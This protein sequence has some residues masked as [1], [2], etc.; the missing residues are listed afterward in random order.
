[1]VKPILKV[2]TAVISFRLFCLL[3]LLSIS[4]CAS[5][6][7]ATIEK[8]GNRH[9]EYALS[10]QGSGT[11]VFENGLGGT[12]DWWADVYPE[13]A[14][15]TTVFAYNRPGY[16][17][18]DPVL[19]PRDGMHIVDELRS[20]LRSKGLNPPYV[21]VGHSLGGLYMQL[22]ARRFPDEVDGLILVD[23]THPA[24]FQ[25]NGSPAHWPY[26]FHLLYR[27]GTSEVEK[28][29][30]AA[31]NATGESVLG[32]PA[33]IGK[34]VV[35]LSALKPMQEKSELADDANEKR[36][37]IAH[38]YPG[39]KQIWVDSGHGIPLEKPGSVITAIRETLQ[40]KRRGNNIKIQ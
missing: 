10:K 33:F 39:A 24:Q 2:G 17:E 30:M 23:S 26:W 29:E 15:D 31:V 18:S 7:I 8:I 27:L 13:I 16:G 12:L 36:K 14:K 9:V 11:V 34:P 22:F 4:G 28:K 38:L 40:L 1:M 25:G 20:L 21:L 35:V 6:P 3:A 19:T 5:L 32:L 37:D